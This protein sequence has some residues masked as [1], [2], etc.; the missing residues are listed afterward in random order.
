MAL[1]IDL[2]WQE[3]GNFHEEIELDDEAAA[4]MISAGIDMSSVDDIFSYLKDRD[5]LIKYEPYNYEAAELDQ[6][7]S[8]IIPA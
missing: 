7:G 2:Y 8:R 5:E 1:K 3:T 6:Q 4:E